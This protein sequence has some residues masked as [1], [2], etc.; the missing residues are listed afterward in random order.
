MAEM[1]AKLH[2]SAAA[3]ASTHGKGGSL[4]IEG[5]CSRTPVL[6][7]GLVAKEVL[8]PSRP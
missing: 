5:W 7:G 6:L 4:S 1:L 2:H 3:S 8:M